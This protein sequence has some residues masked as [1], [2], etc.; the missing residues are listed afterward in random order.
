MSYI[1]EIFKKQNDFFLSNQTKNLSF[2]KGQL[3][4]LLEILKANEEKMNEAIYADFKKSAFENYETELAL[5]YGEIKTSIKK[6]KKWSK[7]RKIKTNLANIPG[8]SFMYPEPLGTSLIIG[9]WNYPY[10]LTLSPLVPAIAAG[11]TVILKPSELSANTSKVMAEIINNNFEDKYIHVIEGGITETTELLNQPFDKIFFTGSTRVGKIVMK[12]ASQHLSSVTLELGGK[13]PTFI[14]PDANLKVAA[15]RIVWGKFL[16]A[17]QTC[18][19][20]DYLLIHKSIKDKFLELLVKNIEKIHQNEFVDNEAYVS[21]I[22]EANFHRLTGLV[23]KDKI[24]YGGNFDL[25]NLIIHPTI[26]HNISFNDVIME[27]EIFG[28]ILPVI[29]YENINEVIAKVKQRPKPLSL[30]VFTKNKRLR[31]QILT[32]ISFG[33][34]TINDTILHISNPHLPFGGTGL[35][36]F[37]KYHDK[38]GFDTFSHYKGI[39]RKATW[40]EPFMKYPPYTNFKKKILQFFL[41]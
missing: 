19:A 4:K 25:K 14:L 34:A 3:K 33:G 24:Y 27:D 23:E 39:L 1:Q 7:R 15:K 2:R 41:E 10:Q 31:E 8:S 20:P 28:P 38:A 5:V 6:L 30:Y 32:E 40:F 9:A 18:I 11:N 35:S 12:A 17:G 21:I 29:E 26:V 37:G 16:N 36:G 13:S 22:N